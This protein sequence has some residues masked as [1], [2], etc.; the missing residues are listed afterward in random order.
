MYEQIIL[1]LNLGLLRLDNI[2]MLLSLQF[3]VL[4]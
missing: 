3:F 1:S 4:R 2:N